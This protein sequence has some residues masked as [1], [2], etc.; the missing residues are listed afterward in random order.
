MARTMNSSAPQRGPY[1]IRLG[2]GADYRTTGVTEICFEIENNGGNVLNSCPDGPGTRFA[3]IAEPFYAAFQDVPESHDGS[4]A[5]TVTLDFSEPPLAS[6]S[7]ATF[8]GSAGTPSVLQV[9]NGRVTGARQVVPGEANTQWEITVEPTGNDAISI[10]LPVVRNCAA[11]NAVCAGVNRP[12]AE[13]ATATIEGP[14]AAPPDEPFSVSLTNLPWAHDGETAFKFEVHFSKNPSP[15]GYN[16]LRTKTLK[17]RQGTTTITPKKAR[18]LQRGSNQGW[19]ITIQPRSRAEISISIGRT[20]DCSDEGA[21]CTNSTP[22]QML[23]IGAAALVAGPPGLS[24]ADAR[25][26]EGTDATV[27]FAVTLSKPASGTVTVAYATSDGTARA[28]SDYTA[29]LGLLVFSP[30]ETSTTVSV[31]VIDDDHDEGAETFTLTLSS[32]SGGN[33]WLSDATATGTIEN[34]D[35]MPQAWLSRFGRTVAEQV[36]EAVGT[37]LRAPPRAGV[38]ARLAGQAI[39]RPGSGAA[40]TNDAAAL[41]KAEDAGARQRLTALSGWLQDPGPGDGTGLAEGTGLADGRRPGVGLRAVTERDLLTGTAFALTAAAAG[42]AGGLVSLWG[43][44]AVSRF[45]GREGDLSLDGEVASAM[46]GADWTREVVT[47]G[48]LLSHARG[49]GG[50]RGARE[51]TVT[52]TVTGLYPYGRFMVNERVTLWGVAGYGAGA[53]TL[54]PKKPAEESQDNGQSNGQQED[55]QDGRPMRTDMDLMMAAAGLRGVAVEAPADGGFELAV[56]SDAMMVRTSSE[57]TAGLEAAEAE[58]TRLRL[59]LEGSWR[60]LA[61][62]GGELTPSAEIGVRHDGGD[63]ETGFGLDLGGGLAWSHPESGVSA[64][65]RG[66]G[67]LTHESQGFRDRGLSGSFAWDPGRGT[68]RGPKLTLTQT[69]GASA[70]GGADALLGRGTLTG[71]A[72]SDNGYELENRRLELRFGYGFPAFGERFSSTP[73]FGLGLS[74]G[75]REYSLGWRLGLAQRGP[76][77]LELKLETTRRE[78][79]NDNAAEHAVGFQLTARW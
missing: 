33:A 58:V 10:T 13:T 28:G 30:G 49:E 35:A 24:V 45:D 3:S 2:P 74:T 17:V 19:E 32:P 23:S 25:A 73:E 59:G 70:S 16:K 69:V 57:K 42:G 55:P 68:G 63:A 1:R 12:I 66:R 4:T 77:S 31:E 37:R 54:T 43:R 26:T 64:E 65:L 9:A 21:V 22:R 27:D 29:A 51:G 8:A 15:Y 67:L 60:G 39:G 20:A 48:L 40:G 53:L 36:I 61:L 38:E 79:A 5:F 7:D 14:A 44:G 50:Y 11:A 76:A 41:A 34:T 78:P 47:V 71:L 18:R 62:G 75:H 46:L 6:V 56:T 52:S 72:A